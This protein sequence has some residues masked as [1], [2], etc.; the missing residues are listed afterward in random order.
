MSTGFENTPLGAQ[1]EGEVK[2][3]G[4]EAVEGQETAQSGSRIAQPFKLPYENEFYVEFK[5]VLNMR[6]DRKYSEPVT[7]GPLK[8]CEI[9]GF[10]RILNNQVISV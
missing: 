7:F 9:L 5:D 6:E 10:P 3:V 4:P 2:T 8:W 1:H